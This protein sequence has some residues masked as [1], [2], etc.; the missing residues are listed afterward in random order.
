MIDIRDETEKQGVKKADATKKSAER[1][2]QVWPA[3][4]GLL[5]IFLFQ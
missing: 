5:L 2:T 3:A 1:L 4:T